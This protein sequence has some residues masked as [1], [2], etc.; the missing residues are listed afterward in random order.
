MEAGA[1]DGGHLVTDFSMYIQ[2]F[3]RLEYRFR[4]FITSDDPKINHFYY[5]VSRSIYTSSTR[6]VA[7]KFTI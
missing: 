4:K 2:L 7:R 6:H 5:M 3:M 1:K